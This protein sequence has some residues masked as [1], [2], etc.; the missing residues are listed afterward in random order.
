MSSIF[1]KNTNKILM[2]AVQGIA[3]G[4]NFLLVIFLTR[5]YNLETFGIYSM[6]WLVII[7]TLSLQQSM[8]LSPLLTLWA[9]NNNKNTWNGFFQLN[10]ILAVIMAVGATLFAR[11]AHLIA[12]KWVIYQYSTVVFFMVIVFAM[13]LFNRRSLINMGNTDF[14]FLLDTLAYLPPLAAILIFKPPLLIVLIIQV[15]FMGLAT[16]IGV[17]KLK[18]SFVPVNE[19]K[20]LTIEVWKFS[21]WLLLTGVLQWF[22]G[23]FFIVATGTILGASALGIIRMGQSA[24][25]VF[26]VFFIALENRVPFSASRLLSAEGKTKMQNYLKDIFLKGTLATVVAMSLFAI[27]SKQLIIFLYGDDYAPYYWVLMLFAGLQL[28]IFINTLFQITIRTIEKT[29][30][31]FL[32]YLTITVFSMSLAFQV[33]RQW[34]IQ[35]ALAGLYAAQVIGIILYAVSLKLQWKKI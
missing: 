4:S 19:I 30:I 22:S 26:N 8:I 28:F 1:K 5:I 35:G 12:S 18:P 23:N 3:S 7:F 21:S 13:H 16:I 33:V 27:G 24:V 10:L 9:K 29:K 14:V 20:L 2:V 6:I 17:F 34:G 15:S 11:Y 32:V 31:I 25:G